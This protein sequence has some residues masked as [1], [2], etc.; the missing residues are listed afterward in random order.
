[1]FNK[2]VVGNK[3]AQRLASEPVD[4][5]AVLVL[6]KLMHHINR[7]NMVQGTPATISAKMGV[8][9]WEFNHG[10]RELKKLDFVKKYTKW[11]YMISPNLMFNG[12]ERQYHIVKHMW[13]TQTTQGLRE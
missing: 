9:L 5:T 6:M 7:V 12:D 8:T 1:M 3:D 10:I 11:E 2:F 4:K 13:L